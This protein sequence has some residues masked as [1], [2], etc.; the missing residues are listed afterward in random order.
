[1]PDNMIEGLANAAALPVT[2]QVINQGPG[3]WGNVATGLITAGAA[4]VAVIL[5][6]RYTHW[7]EKQAAVKQLKREQLFIA[8]E[9]IF[10]LEQFAE[11][12]AEVATDHGEPDLQGEYS[13]SV[14]S[15]EFKTDDVTG[16]WRTLP[17]R[18]M[19][20]TRELPILQK[21]A[22]RR[23]LNVSEYDWAPY[24]KDS[25]EERQYQYARLGLKALILAIRLRKMTG[26]PPTRLNTADWSAQPQMWSVWRRGRENRTR[27]C[28]E[29][30]EGVI[31]NQ[32]SSQQP[33]HSGEQT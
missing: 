12:C 10:L 4:I 32:L 28:R 27:L 16:D 17:A 9:L 25:F 23:I 18:I 6:H 21:E 11:G 13:V 30:A 19:Y 1:M 15:P 3:I 14:K 8:T 31:T 26:L 33:G 20:R 7:R 5:T 22:D 24:Y 29:R 2:V